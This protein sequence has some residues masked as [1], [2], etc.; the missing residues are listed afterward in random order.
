MFPVSSH[1]SSR[2]AFG[3]SIKALFC[4]AAATT[5]LAG[6]GRFYADLT[7]TNDTSFACPDVQIIEDGKEVTFFNPGAG[8]D[9]I[10]VQFE[11]VFST[12]T[13]ECI[14]DRDDQEITLVV[15]YTIEANRGPAAD[16][17]SVDLPYFIAIVTRDQDVLARESFETTA[18]FQAGNRR[19]RFIEEI[20][21]V[22][23]VADDRDGENFEV[24][25]SF[26]LTESQL[27]YNREKRLR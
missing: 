11:A 16:S 27:Q 12:V 4:V 25:A 13:A 23:P 22:I 7:G 17:M 20:E 26:L 21:Q 1:P 19:T 5:A 14:Y 6:C 9:I 18:V 2:T 8:R 3:K 24:L 10:D 15:Q